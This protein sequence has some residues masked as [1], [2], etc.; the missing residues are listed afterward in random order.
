MEPLPETRQ[1]LDELAAYDGNDL[2]GTLHAMG[3]RAKE[4][5][6]ECVGLSLTMVEDG[7][8][9]TLVATDHETAVLDAV[10]YLDGGPCIDALETEEILEVRDMDPLSEER[11]SM[12]ARASSDSGVASSLSLPLLDNGRVIGGVNLYASTPEA[13]HGRHPELAEALC[14]SAAGAVADADLEFHTRM[15][16]TEAP[17]RI[18]ELQHIDVAVGILAASQRVSTET[19]REL[20]RQAALRAGISEFQ[21]AQAVRHL[22][23][24]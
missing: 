24:P 3:L 1:A 6:P 13:F 17:R 19:A 20:L 18:E 12:Y 16:A 7:L 2:A 15:Q 22:Q 8:T 14:A 11:W 5:V 10:Q 4:I 9:F 21:A 23:E